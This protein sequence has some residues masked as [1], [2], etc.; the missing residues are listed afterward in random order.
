VKRGYVSH[1][2]S[3]FPG[4]LKTIYRLLGIPAQ[5]LF[6]A[7]A[8]DLSDLFTAKPDPAPYKLLN[9]D[10]RIFDPAKARISTSGKPSPRMDH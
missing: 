6:D 8:T 7:S 10:S 5:N 1:R 3:S 9:V 4:L 2:N